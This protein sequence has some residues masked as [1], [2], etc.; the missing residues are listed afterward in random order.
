MKRIIVSITVV[1][2]AVMTC[3]AQ[4]FVTGSVGMDFS[5]A[6]SKT[7]STSTDQPST[8]TFEIWPAAGYFFSDNMGIGFAAGI[9]RSVFNWKNSA[10]RKDFTTEFGVEAF[11]LYKLAEV[12]NLAFIIRGGVGYL[13]S[14]DKTKIGN[15]T[16][17]GNPE[18]TVGVFVLPILSY[19]LNER[20]SVEAYSDFLRFGYFRTTQKTG[21]NS[22]SIENDFGFG[23]NYGFAPVAVGIVYKF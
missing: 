13:N 21:S 18:N 3:N 17:E 14:K 7:G 15:N 9:N 20:F 4:Y 22:K 12:E 1:L 6:K 19:S 8:F 10:E 5:S 2:V 11:G 16:T 23:A